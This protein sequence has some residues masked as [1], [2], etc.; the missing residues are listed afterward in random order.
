MSYL[1]TFSEADIELVMEALRY[2]G[3]QSLYG[4]RADRA[5]QMAMELESLKE[6]QEK[7]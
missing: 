4:S 3:A 2:M 5:Q 7:I 1:V 6:R